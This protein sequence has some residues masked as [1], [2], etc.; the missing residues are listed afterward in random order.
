MATELTISVTSNEGG[1]AVLRFVGS[2]DATNLDRADAAVDELLVTG[3]V[4]KIV[5]DL[6]DLEYLNSKAVGFLVGVS[7]KVAQANA[8]LVLAALRSN[9]E[10]II[11]V[12]GLNQ[13]IPVVRTVEEAKSMF[14]PGMGEQAPP[15]A[16]A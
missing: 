16:A 7:Q 9:V 10:D 8:T 13:I 3:S 2:L 6:S 15:A 11:T 12:V 4:R 5:L 1:C 14:D